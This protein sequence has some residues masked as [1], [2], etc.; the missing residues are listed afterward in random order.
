MISPP[1]LLK[2]KFVSSSIVLDLRITA[3]QNCE[4]VSRRARS[5]GSSKFVSLNSRLESN[6][7]GSHL[8][9]L[10]VDSRSVGE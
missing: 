4:A 7:E 6:E 8:E 9:T 3:Q 1:R 5:Q 2:L 10:L